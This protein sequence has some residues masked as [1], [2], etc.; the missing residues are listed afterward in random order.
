MRWMNV[1]QLQNKWDEEAPDILF[2]ETECL[3]TSTYMIW[4]TQILLS[5]FIYCGNPENSGGFG[6]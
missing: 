5:A 4:N 6:T 1:N 3:L 2:N